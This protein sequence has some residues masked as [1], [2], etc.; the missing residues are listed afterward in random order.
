MTL[1]YLLASVSIGTAGTGLHTVGTLMSPLLVRSVFHEHQHQQQ[2]GQVLH[3]TLLT[4]YGTEKQVGVCLCQSRRRVVG[5]WMK[6]VYMMRQ[7][8]GS[9]SEMLMEFGCVC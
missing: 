1:L 2:E 6:Q 9:W 3:S 8:L 5:R 7:L 4:G